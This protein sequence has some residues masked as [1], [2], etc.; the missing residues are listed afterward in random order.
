ML[1]PKGHHP[2]TLR[3]KD[4]SGVVAQYV[5]ATLWRAAQ[6]T[7]R[8]TEGAGGTIRYLSGTKDRGARSPRNGTAGVA[9]PY[10]SALR[11]P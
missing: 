4:R 6:H 2:K 5:A 7:L 8:P 1:P 9:A 3:Q 11:I 10:Y